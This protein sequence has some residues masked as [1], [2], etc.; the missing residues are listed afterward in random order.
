MGGLGLEPGAGVL[1]RGTVYRGGGGHSQGPAG[2]Q[3]PGCSWP[4]GPAA[5]LPS[6]LCGDRLSA[7]VLVRV[8]L[9]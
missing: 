8:V 7:A 4:G 5:S 6:L 1:P 3:R 2:G 9:L